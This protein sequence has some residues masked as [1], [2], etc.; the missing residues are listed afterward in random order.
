MNR[1]HRLTRPLVLAAAT[2]AV[3]ALAAA[4]AA[5]AQTKDAPPAAGAPRVALDTTAGRIV[6]ELDAQRAPKSVANFLRYVNEGFYDG[7]IF[8]RVIA[9][10]M[11]QGGGFTAD[12]AQ[13]QTREPIANEANN[14][15]KNV[16]GTIAMARTANPNSAT[17]QFFI[18]VV[19]NQSLDY[20][21]FDGAGYAVF[22][23]VVEGMDAVD[24]IRASKTSTHGMFQDVPVT[25]VVINSA[26]VVK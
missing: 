10:F 4:G 8:H 11:I 3:A 14:G 18:N 15:L 21:S 22:G 24:R 20:P 7:T 5:T 17:A 13:K 9:N 25:A 23:H 19:D 16:R 2:L 12:M 26:R 1:I 6:L